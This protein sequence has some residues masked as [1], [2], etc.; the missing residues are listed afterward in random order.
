M[1]KSGTFGIL[2]YSEPFQYCAAMHIRNP[3]LFIKIDQLSVIL[4]IQNP[5]IL[6]I[7]LY[8]EP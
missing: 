3:V 4:E 7:L 8:S 5:G 6:T 2:E 1:Q